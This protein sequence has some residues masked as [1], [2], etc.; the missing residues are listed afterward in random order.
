M[1]TRKSKRCAAD[2]ATAELKIRV[3]PYL[4]ARIC[5][6]AISRGEVP[7]AWVRRV[8]RA[9]LDREAQFNFR[10]PPKIDPADLAQKPVIIHAEED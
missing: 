2:V 5:G 8:L 7:A 3:Q 9:A 10:A 6:H 1:K 4:K